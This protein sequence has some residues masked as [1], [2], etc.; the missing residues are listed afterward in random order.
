MSRIAVGAVYDRPFLLARKGKPAV[1]D[2]PDRT[3]LKRFPEA[4]QDG[5][6]NQP[7][8]KSSFDT[9][10]DLASKAKDIFSLGAALIDKGE[11]VLTGNGGWT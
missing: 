3:Q 5:F 1:I 10:S 11:R 6:W 8:P 4:K 2:R 7:D 9:A